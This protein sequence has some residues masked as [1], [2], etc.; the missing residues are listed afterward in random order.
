MASSID[1]VDGFIRCYGDIE[2]VQSRIYSNEANTLS[3]GA[4][5]IADRNTLLDPRNL[6]Q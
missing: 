3:S 4:V 1:F 5:V 6:L 2:A